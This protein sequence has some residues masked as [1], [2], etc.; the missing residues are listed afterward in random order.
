[1]ISDRNR[2]NQ[3]PQAQ[4]GDE[5]AWEVV[6]YRRR[7]RNNNR[8]QPLEANPRNPNNQPNPPT[9]ENNQRNQANDDPP[10]DVV[11]PVPADN[12]DR[13]VNNNANVDN[14]GGPSA[15]GRNFPGRQRY[16][17]VIF[18]KVFTTTR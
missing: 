8:P 15:N 13:V 6:Q 3:Q 9:Q 11:P 7:G 5:Q 16:Q 18:D 14:G 10:A 2:R 4:E 17:Q 12:R 1:M